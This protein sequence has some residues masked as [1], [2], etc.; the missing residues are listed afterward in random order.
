MIEKKILQK[1]G[2]FEKNVEIWLYLQNGEQNSAF[3]KIDTR[4][5]PKVDSIN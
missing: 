2:V 5:K 1:E 3:Y 4:K